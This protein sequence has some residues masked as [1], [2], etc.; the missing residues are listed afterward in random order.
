MSD[1]H[2]K[3]AR[4]ERAKAP[5]TAVLGLVI[6][7]LTTACAHP[8]APR[9]GPSGSAITPDDFGRGPSAYERAAG[10][11]IVRTAGLGIPAWRD[12]AAL[13]QPFD[14]GPDADCGTAA[15]AARGFLLIHG[16]TD[17]PYV[18]RDLAERLRELDRCAVIAAVALPGHAT[19]PGDL[20]G[21]RHEDWIAAAGQAVD[22]M[23]ARVDRVYLV[24]F[25][26]GA[27]LALHDVASRGPRNIA[28]LVLL[29]P[30]VRVNPPGWAWLAR[31]LSWLKTWDSGTSPG[32]LFASGAYPDEDP[33]KYE[34][35][36]W[37]AEAEIVALTDRLAEVT[38]APLGV[39]VFMAI[40]SRDATVDA[41]SALRLFC[42][43]APPGR[44]KLVWY[45]LA[46]GAAEARSELR[47][48][49]ADDACL[50]EVEV[51]DRAATGAAANIR[52]FSHLSLPNRPGNPVYGEGGSYRNC[53]RYYFGDPARYASCKT[54][55]AE[56]VI[57]GENS[58]PDAAL[59]IQRL[60]YNPDFEGMLAR[61]EAFLTAN[62]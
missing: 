38:R 7:M 6:G 58:D 17:S 4:R 50:A 36:P 44:R 45:A 53:V 43:A 23:G 12:G 26:T 25:S 31:P 10:E 32:T 9:F 42:R 48:L 16:F 27:A 5:W 52:D 1:S 18:L 29:S 55:P 13:R 54:R 34:S 46:S 41:P 39:P 14:T 20:L 33:V 56:A 40:A 30:L 8:D 62:P 2:R 60:T 19:V 22:A 21:V 35:T 61:L 47:G 3:R 28:G 11:K 15:R 51:R 59:T 37:H 57:L 49:G 24:G